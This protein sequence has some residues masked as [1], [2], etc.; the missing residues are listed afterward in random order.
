MI[1]RAN[2][3]F[4]LCLLA[5]L[6]VLNTACATSHGRPPLSK[7]TN[8]W[9]KYYGEAI[10]HQLKFVNDFE[11]N[12]KDP[13]Y[14]REKLRQD[15]NEIMGQLIT[16]A[17]EVHTKIDENLRNSRAYGNVFMDAAQIVTT[18]LS[19]L[20]NSAAT[21]DKFATAALGAKGFQESV[22]K[23]LFYEH[24]TSAIVNQMHLLRAEAKKPLVKGF[25]R[26][27]DDYPL[28][29]AISDWGA[30]FLSGNVT[31]ALSRMGTD[32]KEKELKL[33]EIIADL[34]ALGKDD[35]GKKAADV[36]AAH[37]KGEAD[38]AKAEADRAAEV[39]NLI[40]NR[41]PI[42]AADWVLDWQNRLMDLVGKLTDERALELANN[43]PGLDS[44]V[45]QV[46][47]GWRRGVSRAPDASGARYF[48]QSTIQ[49]GGEDD[50][51]GDWLYM[52]E[53]ALIKAQIK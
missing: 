25:S 15:R 4:G 6:P 20:A 11:A 49:L 34:A 1:P 22:D 21:A 33:L 41:T 29:I 8:Q 3:L 47:P 23:R 52:W 48:L 10:D 9:T 24:A 40:F 12:R 53:T 35:T 5:G 26:P 31:E 42:R 7:M 38:A 13:G 43:P 28:S 27:I 2:V 39:A 19:V 45:A 16:I 50:S 51:L 46:F 44:Q 36:E 30:Y 32:A 14:D 17:E 37:K 18:G